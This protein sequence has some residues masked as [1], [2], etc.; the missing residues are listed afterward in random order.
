MRWW[1]PRGQYTFSTSTEKHMLLVEGEMSA[2]LP[3]GDWQPM[4]KGGPAVVVPRGAS[5]DVLAKTD[6][7]YICYYR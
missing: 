2:R 4:R 3:G 6:V 5:F 1:T 7:A